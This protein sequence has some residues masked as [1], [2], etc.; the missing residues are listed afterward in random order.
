MRDDL[1]IKFL[2]ALLGLTLLV[3]AFLLAYQPGRGE[4]APGIA[5][6][7]WTMIQTT[8]LPAEKIMVFSKE[9]PAGFKDAS[10]GKATTGPIKVEGG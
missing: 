1:K 9:F 5:Q 6:N 4:K 10:M 2:I 3:P 8:P 7:L